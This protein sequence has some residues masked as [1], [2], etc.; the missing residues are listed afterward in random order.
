MKN[1]RFIYFIFLFSGILNILPGSAQN[2]SPES[3][4]IRI[5]L[6]CDYCDHSYIKRNIPFVNFTRDSK[7]AQV[8]ILITVQSTAS[9]GH[10]FILD[11]I[12]RENYIEMNQKLTYISEQS[13]TDDIRRKGL[14][15]TIIMGLMPYISQTPVS[16]NIRISYDGKKTEAEQKPGIDPWNYWVF[17]INLSGDLEAEKS[18]NKITLSNRFRAERITEA[19]KF[20]SDFYYRHERET[21]KDNDEEIESSLVNSEINLGLVKSLTNH[22]SF[23]FFSN[24]IHS[25]YTNLDQQISVAPALEYNFYPWKLSNRKIFTLGYYLGYRYNKYIKETLYD[26]FSEHTL[27]HYL[28]FYMEYIQPWGELDAGINFSQYFHDPKYYRIESEID[29]YFRIT[30]GL[31]LF[32]ESNIESIHDQLYLPKGDAELEDILL[33]RRRLETNYD[34]RF[35]LGIQYTFGSIYNNIVNHRF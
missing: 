3:N 15:R 20:E 5:F 23:G 4:T 10:R 19:W 12:G 21:F 24:F 2:Q 7:Q 32:V 31:S 28:E 22:W 11:F 1:T 16:S 17:S 30:K 29:V 26:K 14:T 6:D 13:E 27:L 25:T 33:K 18:Q 8:H 9:G 34:V 35:E